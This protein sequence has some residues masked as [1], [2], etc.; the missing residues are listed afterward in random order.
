MLHGHVTVRHCVIAVLIIK[1]ATVSRSQSVKDRSRANN[2]L[3]KIKVNLRT[4]VELCIS[5][6]LNDV[7]LIKVKK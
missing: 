5:T 1:N 4:K 7:R 3:R 2:Y 6:E